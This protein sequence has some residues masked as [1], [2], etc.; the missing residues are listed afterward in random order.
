MKKM[1]IAFKGEIIKQHR[2]NFYSYFV[3]FSLLVWPILGFFTVYFTYKPFELGQGSS[4]G[5][6]NSKD[7]MLFLSTGYMAYTCYW[8][9]VQNAWQLSNHER[10]NGTLEI[11]FMSPTNRM[12]LIYGKALGPL[13]QQ[14]WMF[15]FF[16][17]IIIIY[18]GGL[19]LK[20]ILLIP[21]IFILLIVSATFWGGMLNAMF[22]MSRDSSILM[23]IF[24]DP[25]V[26]FSGVKVP[27]NEFPLW[28]KLISSI[29]PLTYC[30]NLIRGVFNYMDFDSVLSNFI[31]LVVCLLVMFI[32]TKYFVNKAE[33]LNRENGEFSVY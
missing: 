11:A 14:T 33:K 26:L 2:N 16:C 5:I 6:N 32:I 4:I 27:V 18:A 20:N 9:M 25:M 15:L 1:I 31:K 7:L 21:I 30:L 10:M 19:T 3:Y 17:I 28:A 29:F 22:L 13:L 23:N 8:S 12:I 24:D